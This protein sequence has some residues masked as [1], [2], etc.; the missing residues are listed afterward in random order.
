[1]GSLSIRC[2]VSEC[3]RDC[4]SYLFWPARIGPEQVAQM[5]RIKE[6]ILDEKEA[7]FR[8]EGSLEVRPG[9]ESVRAGNCLIFKK[10]KFD[11]KGQFKKAAKRAALGASAAN[12]TLRTIDWK[13]VE[14]FDHNLSSGEHIDRAKPARREFKKIVA[15]QLKWLIWLARGSNWRI[16]L[17]CPR[18]KSAAL[19]RANMQIMPLCVS[20]FAKC[21]LLN[22][23]CRPELING[24][25]APLGSA[26]QSHLECGPGQHTH[27]HK[28]IFSCR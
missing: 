9:G 24:P 5:K 25:T 4:E 22:G 2:D 26:L 8:G 13:A 17:I 1:M 21:H 18:R 12:K 10:R 6:M 14:Q 27:T 3:E 7:A 28:T 16:N 23:T 11:R 20:P 15:E 19:R